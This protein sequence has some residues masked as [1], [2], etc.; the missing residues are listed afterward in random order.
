MMENKLKIEKNTKIYVA[1]PANV[2]TGGPELLHQLVYELNKLGLKSFMY[3]YYKKKEISPIHEAYIKYKNPF[4]DEI[5]DN[6]DN[7][8]ITPERN[9]GIIYHYKDI[10]K[11]IWWLSV[12]NYYKLFEGKNPV[13]KLLKVILYKFNILKAYQFGRNENIIHFVQSEYAKQHLLEKGISSIYF[14]GDY[15]DGVFIR[16][17]LETIGNNRKNIV[18]FNPKKGIEFTKK[19]IK[20]GQKIKFIPIENMTT[21]KVAKLLSTAKIYIDFGNHPGKDRIPREAAISNCCVITNK[22]GSAK[23]YKDVPIPDEFKFDDRDDNIYKI[24]N[25]IHDSF[26]NYEDNVEKFEEYREI[27]KSEQDN[28]IADI[29]DI[30]QV[31]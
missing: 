7:V 14:L 15:L 13:K 1:C 3:Y 2:A 21:N 9:T 12:D 26:S 23:Y 29:K 18:V 31:K 6:K 10:Q 27:I 17:Q 19:I 4:V 5:E 24:I 20:H 11:V 30:F 28:F 25:K 22:R 16:N 8:I